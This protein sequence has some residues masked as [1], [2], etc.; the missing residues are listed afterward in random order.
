M[1]LLSGSQFDDYLSE[2]SKQQIIGKDEEQLLLLETDG[3]IK[4]SPLS[5]PPLY[6]DDEYYSNLA[7]EQ[8]RCVNK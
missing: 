5:L 1:R 3:S 7:K 2:K 8:S 4:S 6:T